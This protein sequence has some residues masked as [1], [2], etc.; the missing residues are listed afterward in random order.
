MWKQLTDMSV[1][2]RKADLILR[3]FLEPADEDYLTA[4]WAYSNAVFQSFY[5][6]AGQAFEKYLKAILLF[7]NVP[8]L[9]YGHD[10]VKLLTR[11]IELDVNGCLPEEMNLPETMALGHDSWHGKP[12]L[13]FAEYLRVYGSTNN[14]Y[15]FNGIF[16]NGPVLHVL[17][18]MCMSFRVFIRSTNFFG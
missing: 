1:E 17:D 11:A 8:T 4:R 2:E 10:L 7:Q 3:L 5:W 13:L 9:D 14:R 6:L 18:A 15:A 12:P 16:V